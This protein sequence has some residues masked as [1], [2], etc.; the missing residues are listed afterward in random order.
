METQ[1]NDISDSVRH[2]IAINNEL[3]VKYVA[4]LESLDESLLFLSKKIGIDPKNFPHQNRREQPRKELHK[5]FDDEM[6]EAS[7]K[8]FDWEI[9]NLEYSFD[10]CATIKS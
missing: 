3:K 4:K 6:I 10:S 2:I 8:L 7:L 1:V 9:K 5:I